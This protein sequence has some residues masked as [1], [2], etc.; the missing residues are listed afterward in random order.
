[1]GVVVAMVDVGI[2]W[3]NV[4]GRTGWQFYVRILGVRGSG[5]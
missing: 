2:R 3:P 5:Q 4:C 1:M